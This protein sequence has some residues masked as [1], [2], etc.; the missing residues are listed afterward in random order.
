MW[1]ILIPIVAILGSFSVPVTAIIMD[2]KRRRLQ[3]EER[4]AMIEKGMQPPPLQEEHPFR[5][6]RTPEERRLRALRAGVVLLFLG[7]GLGV[8]ACLLGYVFT[9][10]FISPNLAAIMAL[11][12]AVVGFLGLGNLVYYAISGRART[13]D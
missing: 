11:G 7:V 9:E 12:A 1:G 2:Y 10:N 4:R 8:G 6:E 5:R 13:P 3:S